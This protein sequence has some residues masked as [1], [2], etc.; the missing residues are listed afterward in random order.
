MAEKVTMQLSGLALDATTLD[1]RQGTMKVADNIV[2]ERANTIELRPGMHRRNIS[3]DA[4]VTDYHPTAMVDH[5][6][7]QFVVGRTAGGAFR[8]YST[9]VKSYL[10]GEA[11]PPDFDLAS[12]SFAH[13]RGNL[14]LTTKDGVR[15]VIEPAG[16]D[17]G[18]EKNFYDSGVHPALTG[19]AALFDNSGSNRALVNGKSVAYQWCWT[20]EDS[21]GVITRSAPSPWMKVT[22]GA[23]A[24]RDVKLTIPLQHQITAP[25]TSYPRL[26]I[27]RSKAITGTPSSELFLVKD[28]AMG[29]SDLDL[30]SWPNGYEFT[31]DVLEDNLGAVLYSSPGRDG[32]L[33]ENHSPPLCHSLAT[34][35]DCT[36]FANTKRRHGLRLAVLSSTHNAGLG[37]DISGGSSTTITSVETSISWVKKMAYSGTSGASS[38]TLDLDTGSDPTG[39]NTMGLQVGMGVTLSFL[40][41]AL[42][43]TVERFPAGAGLASD[44]LPANTKV[45]SLGNDGTG[46]VVVGLSNALTG[47]FST[48]GGVNTVAGFSDIVTVN[49]LEHWAFEL[50]KVRTNS[51]T[52]ATSFICTDSESETA[53]HLARAINSGTRDSI[54]AAL[55]YA[56]CIE[57]PLSEDR[58]AEIHLTRSNLSASSFTV[59]TT[60]P[61]AVDI[62]GDPQG[63][64]GTSSQSVRPNRIFYSKPDQPEHVPLLNYLNA[65]EADSKVLAMTPLRGSLIVWTTAGLYRV[66]GV[67][68]DSWRCDLLEEGLVLIKPEAVCTLDGAAFGWTNRGVV[69]VTEAGVGNV[70]EGAIGRKLTEKSITLTTAGTNK[71]A[72]MLA[73]PDRGLVFLGLP[74]AADAL[75]ASELYCFSV[76]TGAWTRW[77]MDVLAGCYVPSERAIVL[78]DGPATLR[79]RQEVTSRNALATHDGDFVLAGG[80]NVA[81]EVSFSGAEVATYTPKVDDTVLAIVGSSLYTG[82]VATYETTSGE[83]VVTASGDA[84]TT[85]SGEAVLTTTPGVKYT[86]TPAMGS[87]TLALFQVYDAIPAEMEWNAMLPGSPQSVGRWREIQ[88]HTADDAGPTVTGEA[89]V[90]LG[91]RSERDTAST[92]TKVS[93]P[94]SLETVPTKNYRAMIPR[95]AHRSS[96]L[97][98]AVKIANAGWVWK[99]AGLSLTAEAAGGRGTR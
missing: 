26:E 22:N 85:A 79:L 17:G 70:S 35:G 30:A 3:W 50:D 46:R 53:R 27:Y 65:G 83:P 80:L 20:L 23:G 96:H 69:Q 54:G 75:Y 87:G 16:G 4:D 91:G 49:G 8:L 1:S 59:S 5:G 47:T 78:A 74:P 18:S 52:I 13:A 67:A 76:R 72:F 24:D 40:D 81:G 37:A 82:S 99:I 36:W 57:D 62:K 29:S 39:W 63:S 41:P 93:C 14:Y 7:T 10:A 68:P 73:H 64:A 32:A 60:R 43:S 55:V 28:V 42:G 61:G 66:S 25:D 88:L 12:T 58:P 56:R 97:Y 84:V 98:P 51:S 21:N 19:T 94:L 11:E 95:S 6:G 86:F 45:T 2:I 33:K 15:K 90:E 77:P 92:R 89:F 9:A 34:F 71:G 44:L 31:D 48:G 38:I